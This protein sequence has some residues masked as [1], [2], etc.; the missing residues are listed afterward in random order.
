MVFLKVNMIFQKIHG[1]RKLELRDN[2]NRSEVKPIHNRYLNVAS[3]NNFEAEY[4]LTE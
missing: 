1:R 2:Y 3:K 4:S